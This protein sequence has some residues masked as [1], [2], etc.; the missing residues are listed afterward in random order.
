M[1]ES[2]QK[3][4]P[5]DFRLIWL[6]AAVASVSFWVATRLFFQVFPEASIQFNVNRE[7]SLPVAQ[8]LLRRL[9]V[10]NRVKQ[11]ADSS[12]SLS[13]SALAGPVDLTSYHHVAIF[14][15]DDTAKTFLERELGLEK[16]NGVMGREVRLWRWKHRW[17]RPLHKEEFQVDVSPQ[18]DITRFQH[19]IEENASGAD[20][21]REQ[22]Q[23]LAEDFLQRTLQRDL[24][25]LEFIEVSTE[26][27]QRRTDHLFG[28]RSKE[29]VLGDAQYRFS[30]RIQGN[31]LGEYDEYLK[32]PDE[33]LR[34]Y[35]KLRSLND[36]TATVDFI[37]LFSTLL[38][39][40]VVLILHVRQRDIH[41]RVATY[42]GITAFVLTFLSR[43]NGF[44]LSEFSYVTTDSYGSFWT[45]LLLNTLFAS[46]AS[47]AAIFLI[48]ASA[49]PLYRRNYGN[50]VSLFN[51]FRWR[52]LQSKEFFVASLVGTTLTF[53]F[54]AYDSL[55]YL[56]AQKLGAWAPA[57]VP[58]SDL[59]NTRIPWAF[60]LFFGFFPAVSE[61]FVSRMFS[62]PFFEKIC[63][64][65][66]LAVWLASF[67]WGFGHANYPNQPFYIRG[68]EVGV[69]GLI[70]SLIFLK[71]GIVATLVWHY[72]VDALYTAFLLLR[73]Q[74]LYLMI[75]GGLSAGIMLV[76]FFIALLAYLK[77]RGFLSDQPINNASQSV[78]TVAAEPTRAAPVKAPSI[79]YLSLSR[80]RRLILVSTSLLLLIPQ[81]F[82][83]PR[84]GKFADFAI[85]RSQAREIAEHYLEKRGID[86][87][88]Y[89]NT[90]YPDQSLDPVAA[91][92]LLKYSSV[93]AM[94][95]IYSQKVKIYFWV[96][97]FYKPL[98]EEEYRIYIDP[99]EKIVNAFEH[100][101]SENAP[102]ASLDKVSA[103][104]LAQDYLRKNGVSLED[105]ELKEANSEKKKARQDYAFVWE[106]KTIRF[107]EASMRLRLQI[108]GDEVSNYSTFIKVPEEWRRQRERSTVVDSVLAGIRIGIIALL[109]GWGIWTFL[110][111][112]RQ[113]LIRW[114]PVLGLSVSLVLLQIL[115]SLNALPSLFQDYPTSLAPNVFVVRS[116]SSLLIRHIFQFLYLVVLFGLVSSL[117]P[118]CWWMF[119]KE[120]RPRFSRDALLLSLTILV[121]AFGLGRISD[122]LV[123][124][125]H[126][127]ALLPAFALLPEVNHFLPAFS[128][129]TRSV[130][131]SLVY[132]SM[133]AIVIYIF[134]HVLKKPSSR[135]LLFFLILLS[136][137][138]EEA[139]GWGEFAFGLAT[140]AFVLL[141][142][143][144]L[145][146]FFL[147]QNFPAYLATVL[148]LSLCHSG[149]ELLSQSSRFFKWNGAMLLILGI[150]IS[151]KLVFE[152]ARYGTMQSKEQGESTA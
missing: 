9:G 44:P 134:Q 17:F 94:N 61:E 54:F 74:N 146:R 87:R 125:F 3:L 47:G 151:L 98:E 26:K 136:L 73:S 150:L 49:E 12:V 144:T 100:L 16:A 56:V 85:T 121:G 30:V 70:V 45:R 128:L 58:Y 116:M 32:V 115:S 104:Q 84:F 80:N 76:P 21:T 57:E 46:A 129:F 82:R 141:L 75:S 101:I 97:R 83:I 120:N 130:H 18:G 102:G 89:R 51:L 15:Y 124:R 79:S 14:D 133:L 1:P 8:D 88:S 19:L 119:R 24:S 6:C 66:W 77:N 11:D 147:R 106:S 92:Y 36:T 86:W 148:F 69:G 126:Q 139:S 127:F 103:L 42:F 64:S 118:E 142:L 13:G 93:S 52:G 117:Y 90:I 152:T 137:L 95:E 39:M 50:R 5:K 123:Q 10:A 34:S 22:A 99:H 109:S 37:F 140:Q 143:L 28:W 65:R 111:K 110:S 131:S 60:V 63:R 38:A 53:F 27:R 33:W 78:V 138:S 113:G 145:I 149:Y 55:F 96:V 72:S 68:I 4:N 35:Q 135:L 105:F 62:I 29:F 2:V 31:Q 41:W 122:I 40:L 91:Q 132:T 43:L 112:A 71:F 48:T 7:S 108:K 81:A 20:L 107:Q 25:K 23:A 67:I 114:I 59:L